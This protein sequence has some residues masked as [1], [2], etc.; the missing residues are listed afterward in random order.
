MGSIIPHISILTSILTPSRSAV[1]AQT[2]GAAVCVCDAVYPCAPLMGHWCDVVPSP[3][4]GTASEPAA[5]KRAAEK[6]LHL[7]SFLL[8]GK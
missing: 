2:R 6:T 3:G 1:R 8:G 7:C 5:C 4:S